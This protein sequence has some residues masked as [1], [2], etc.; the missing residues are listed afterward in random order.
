MEEK[1]VEN[2]I[3]EMYEQYDFGSG[4]QVVGSDGWQNDGTSD[5]TRIVYV[6]F[7]PEEGEE[8]SESSHKVSFHVKL[9]ENS[10][11][12]EDVYGLLMSNGTEIGSWNPPKSTNTKKTI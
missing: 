9:K 1:A 5:H 8:P 4:V 11:E 12:V 2:V 10:L 6:E 3:Q 7:E